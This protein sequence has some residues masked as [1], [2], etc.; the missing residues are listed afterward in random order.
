[1]LGNIKRSVF[2]T[3]YTII[4]QYQQFKNCT[5]YEKNKYDG[6]WNLILE[7][8]K[9]ISND[10]YNYDDIVSI[11]IEPT[12]IQE[13]KSLYTIDGEKIPQKPE[14]PNNCCMSGCAHCEWK[15]KLNNIKERLLKEKKP[16]PDIFIQLLES[17]KNNIDPGI[18]AFLE[19]EKSLNQKS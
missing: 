10:L 19:L 6:Y 14:F 18:K 2:K 8:P 11:A 5:Q 1:M 15:D 16:L 7:Q 9:S 12:T 17:N 13:D 4:R 3:G